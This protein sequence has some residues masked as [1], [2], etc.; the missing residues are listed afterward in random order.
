MNSMVYEAS[1]RIR[2]PVYGSTGSIFQLQRQI[3]ELQAELAKAQA[4]LLNMQCQQANLVSLICKELAQMPQ[5]PMFDH[6]SLDGIFNIGSPQSYHQSYSH[7][8]EDSNI[9]EPLWT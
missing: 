3:N 6:N 7:L 5:P 1:A 8:I 9:L 4:E 2:D